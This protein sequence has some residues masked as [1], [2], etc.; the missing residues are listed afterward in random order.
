[1]AHATMVIGER[2]KNT[3]NYYLH[4]ASNTQEASISS[5]DKLQR[6]IVNR[7][8]YH[9][10]TELMDKCLHFI[11][12]RATSLLCILL[13]N[14]IALY[15]GLVINLVLAV[16]LSMLVLYQVYYFF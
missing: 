11:K 13:Y 14:Y 8:V 9:T 12:W 5:R 1:Y 15:G 10:Y 3:P 4:N 7:I 6:F 16:C 2:P